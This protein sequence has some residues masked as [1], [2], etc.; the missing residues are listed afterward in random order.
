MMQ[1]EMTHHMTRNS[2]SM[3]QVMISTLAKA[4]TD[5]AI[6]AKIGMALGSTGI[7][8]EICNLYE[9]SPYRDSQPC[10]TI[11]VMKKGVTPEFLSK[12]WRIKFDEAE[13]VI[14][15]TTQLKRQGAENALSRQFSTNNR[16][17]RYKRINSIFFT[18]TFFVTAAGKST[19]RNTCAQ[20]FVSDK[21]YI[22]LYSM[23]T[24]SEFPSSLKQFCKEIG[25]PMMHW[26][27]TLQGS[28]LPIESK[29]SVI[30]LV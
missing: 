25:V 8:N 1:P 18:D 24:K 16:M 29:I 27:V 12:I 4:V 3:T 10:T 5:K 20:L 2:N 28:N 26:Y 14:Q 13:K 22:E 15:Q 6:D 23:S 30:R 19:R 11:G 9:Q 21:G 17:L 7:R